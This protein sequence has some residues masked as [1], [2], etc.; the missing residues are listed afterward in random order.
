MCSSC[1]IITKSHSKLKEDLNE[2]LRFGE[3][4]Q[5]KSLTSSFS[6]TFLGCSLLSCHMISYG[7]DKQL[8]LLLLLLL[9]TVHSH[10]CKLV[11]YASKLR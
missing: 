2:R 9:V 8:L 4:K 10:E 5:F 11:G 7:S 6:E 3:A 1:T